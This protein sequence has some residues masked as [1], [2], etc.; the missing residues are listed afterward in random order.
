MCTHKANKYV[1]YC[2]LNQHNQPKVIALNIE[3][4]ALVPYAIHTIKGSL[5]VGK[6]LPIRFL[7]LIIPIFESN[8]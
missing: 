8:L 4:I 3:N 2:K 5:Y 7:S 1:A 6:T